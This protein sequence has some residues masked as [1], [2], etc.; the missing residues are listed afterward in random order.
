VIGGDDWAPD[1]IV[2]DAVRAFSRGDE[3]VLRRP[4]AVR[5]WQHVIDPL[6]GY[7]VLARALVEC[8]T[9]FAS[10]W[11]FGPPSDHTHT[12]EELVAAFCRAWGEG[13]GWSVAERAADLHEAAHLTLDPA[14]TKSKQ[15]WTPQIPFREM[16]TFTAEWYRSYYAGAGSAALRELTIAQIFRYF[17][18]ASSSLTTAAP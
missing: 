15:H 3:V 13:S 12:V 1:R 9:E 18:A 14:L 17:P 5:P 16:L 2:P 8:G 11:N 6:A 7:L 4:G 10:A